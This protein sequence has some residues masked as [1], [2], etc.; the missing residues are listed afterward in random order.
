MTATANAGTTP[1]DGDGGRR[2]TRTGRRAS[3]RSLL[4]SALPLSVPERGEGRCP[5]RD[6]GGCPE[7]ARGGGGPQA[8]NVLYYTSAIITGSPVC[9]DVLA[10]MLIASDFT[11]SE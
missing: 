3:P 5:L 11:P 2:A 4:R 1:A 6:G 7:L 10:A 9:A 8:V